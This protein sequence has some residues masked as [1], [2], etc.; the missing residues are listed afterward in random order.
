MYVTKPLIV[1]GRHTLSILCFHCLDFIV[2]FIWNTNNIIYKCVGRIAVV[3]VAS[4]LF[5][6]LKDLLV[7]RI[8]SALV[9]KKWTQGV[10]KIFTIII[11]DEKDVFYDT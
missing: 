1:I 5:I 8:R 9:N 7:S 11:V 2:L 6:S 3:L 10:R 4:F